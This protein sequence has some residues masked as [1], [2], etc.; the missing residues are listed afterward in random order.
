M[1][2]DQNAVQLGKDLGNLIW[3]V[4]SIVTGVG[5]VAKGGVAL[6]RAGISVGKDA[7]EAMQISRAYKIA[8]TE[9]LT[10]TNQ[11]SNFYRDGAPKAFPQVL[12][13]S[14]GVVISANPDKATT[15][16]GTFYSDTGRIINEELGLPKSMLIE[17][18]TQPGS[19]NLLNT[20]D[21]LYKALGPDRFWDQVNKPFLDAAIS[22]G[23]DFVMATNPNEWTALNR[24]LPDG[25]VTRSGFGR[26]YD[27][28]TSKGYVF[29]SQSGKMIK[30]GP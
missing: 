13:T 20:P 6:A 21:S 30:R 11:Y 19:F 14:S 1:G 29:D 16:L 26:E 17:G 2:G 28:L 9:A 5:G 8:E 22:R 27:Y 12:N 15:V 10:S 23:D 7:L 18:S 4:G 24:R 3:Q 25:T